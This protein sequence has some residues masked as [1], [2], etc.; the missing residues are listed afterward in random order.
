MNTKELSGN[1]EKRNCDNCGKDTICYEQGV[2]ART[3]GTLLYEQWVCVE[4]T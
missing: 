2:I 4:C 1:I 3:T